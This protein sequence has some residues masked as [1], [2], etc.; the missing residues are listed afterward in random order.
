M[1]SKN[2]YEYQA[3]EGA[4]HNYPMQIISGSFSY[5]DNSGSLA[6]PSMVTVSN[7]W[8]KWRSSH[9]TSDTNRLLP[10]KLSLVFFS[11]MENQFYKGEFELPIEKIQAL[12]DKG[13][14]SINQGDDVT[15]DMFIV[16]M[17]PGGYVTVWAN[18]YDKTI[19]VFSGYAKKIEGDWSWI[20]DGDD[21]SREAYLKMVIDDELSSLDNPDAFREQ[22]IPYGRWE[23]YTTERYMWEPVLTDMKL[24]DNLIKAIHYYNGEDDYLNVPLGGFHKEKT[25]AIP[26]LMKVTWNRTGY[27]INDLSIHIFFDEEEIFSAFE[28]LG[29][30]NKPLKMELRMEPEKNY[31]FTIWLHNDKDSIELKKTRIKTWKPGGMRYE[32]AGP[33]DTE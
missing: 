32:N 26:D 20:Y 22:A 9:V 31:D 4:P 17:A 1:F 24:R 8:G 6:V 3:S 19:E 30:N 5:H 14:Y 7:G 12:F 25:L 18:G 16:G 2:K 27:L 33:K 15:F 23:K 28:T 29:K 10:G 11:Y 13:Y 21:L